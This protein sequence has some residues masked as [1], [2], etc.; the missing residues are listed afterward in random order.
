M[1][2]LDLFE[3]RPLPR[4]SELP[5]DPVVRA[6]ESVERQLRQRVEPDPPFATGP[7][8]HA[9]GGPLSAEEAERVVRGLSI[10]CS[11]YRWGRIA[12]CL[13]C[14]RASS[15]AIVGF[16]TLMHVRHGHRETLYGDEYPGGLTCFTCRQPIAR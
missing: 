9:T 15:D 4:V 1:N 2:Q 16:A 6:A 12:C 5:A 14:F 11:G 13:A 8:S 7:I 10:R 3:P